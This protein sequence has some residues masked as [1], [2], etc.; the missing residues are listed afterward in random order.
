MLRDVNRNPRR[1]VDESGRV[2]VIEGWHP[3]APSRV[4]FNVKVD[5]DWIGTFGTLD[6]AVD[7]AADFLDVS[8]SAIVL[9]PHQE[10]HLVEPVDE[11]QD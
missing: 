8:A 4:G 5:A 7:A 9:R 1:W 2:R 10:L 6:D 11:D 3:S